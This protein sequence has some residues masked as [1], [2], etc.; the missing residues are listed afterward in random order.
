MEVVL[1][2]GVP[3]LTVVNVVATYSIGVKTINLI[4]TA[5]YRRDIPGKFDVKSFAAI[6]FNIEPPGS[7]KTVVLIFPSGNVVH[8]GA[9]TRGDAISH[10]WSLIVWLNKFLGIP[11]TMC[12]FNIR[13]MVYDSKFGFQVNLYKIKDYFGSSRCKFEDPLFPAARVH[14]LDNSKEV[15]LIY[16]S[17]NLVFTGI[18]DTDKLIE[19]A[20]EMYEVCMMHR[21]TSNHVTNNGKRQYYQMNS[22]EKDEQRLLKLSKELQN[23]SETKR[24][25]AADKVFK[26]S[27]ILGEKKEPNPTSDNIRYTTIPLAD[28]YRAPALTFN[29]CINFE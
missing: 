28:V 27:D 20:I 29:T 24:F 26:I 10:A 16:V 18:K 23:L 1:A 5:L 7:Y 11:C 6:T 15:V 22:A 4:K 19:T 2:E 25:K 8:T 9:K 14:N 21:I 13:N 17:G 12:N 3:P